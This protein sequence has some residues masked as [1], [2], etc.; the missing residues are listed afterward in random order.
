M[1]RLTE[2]S[3]RFPR[4]T[5]LV[6]V[7]VSALGAIAAA[8]A[9]ISAGAYAYIGKEHPAVVRFE[10]FIARF[11]GGYPV[12]V[13]WS[14]GG[15][16]DPCRSVFDE[17]S[18]LMADAV[19]SALAASP[20]VSR[21]SSPAQTPLRVA[22]EDAMLSH[23]FVSDG[24]VDAPRER[25]ADALADPLWV[26]AIVSEDASVGALVVEM[27]TTS[28][29]DQFAVIEQIEGLIEPYRAAGFEFYFSGSPWIEAA[30]YRGTATTTLVVGAA[31]GLVIALCIVVFLRSWQSVVGV[32]ATIGM[33]SAWA[34][35]LLPALGWVRDPITTAA[36][37]L[38]LVLG[39]ADAIHFLTSY[40][41]LRRH[42][43][44]RRP[45][46]IA[47]A[48]D[49]HLPCLMTTLT[50]V[51]GLL[52][53]LTTESPAIAQFGAI[54]AGGVFACLLLTF[55]VLPAL[56]ILLPDSPGA[57]LRETR[58]WDDLLQRII[59]LP[60]AAPW[61]VLAAAGVVTLGC[62]FG[63]T[64]LQTDPSALRAFKQDDPTRKAIEF[65]AARLRPLEGVELEI[66]APAPI[67]EAEI[68]QE[69]ERIEAAL[70]QLDPEHQVRSVVTL[71]RRTA[72]A[73]GSGPLEESNLG[74]VLG[75]LTLEGGA[76]LDAWV[77]LDSRRVRLSLEAPALDVRARRALVDEISGA[78]DSLP[79]GW[80]YAL[81]GPTALHLAIDEA[82]ERTA[83]QS[84]SNSTVLVTLLVMIFLRSVVWG[85]LAMIPNIVPLVVLFGLM[86]LWGIPLEGGSAVVAPIAIGIAVD[87]TIHILHVYVR[88]RR[89]G[90]ASIAAVREATEHC[91]RA[92]VTTSTALALGFLAMTAS[93]FQSVSNI[94][95]LS[96]AAI[97]AAAVAELLL[98][99]ALIAVASTFSRRQWK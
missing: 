12:I 33:G 85:F 96:A 56:L 98:L 37:T 11:G 44:E 60:L 73:L 83:L 27:P 26:G 46:L 78:L 28:I 50:N 38:V 42:A 52:S 86:G 1:V 64:R 34:V 90:V 61:R 2:L 70:E 21:V 95:V 25:V 49:T 5:L 36:P 14:C 87:D 80:D 88:A 30:L 76:S 92:V 69:L 79:D 99:P 29:T 59:A 15:E 9:P 53:F 19:G 91:G 18:L 84:V 68:F 24:R 66:I 57:A 7:L 4:S 89:R 51:A 10:E 43:P 13:A 81:T 35:G 39:T 17:S 93:E 8:R 77:S 40:W 67:F 31:T 74:E 54:A 45:A 23:R 20:Q 65:V 63:L 3:L 62:A 47:A 94:G 55:T 75:I 32:L 71:A 6:A 48:R 22:S 58:R 97:A 72:E 41:N 16:S 82:I